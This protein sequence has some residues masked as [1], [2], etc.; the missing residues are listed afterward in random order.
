MRNT[1][2]ITTVEEYLAAVPE[3]AQSTLRKIRSTILAAAPAAVTESICYGM[4]MFKLNKVM[5][6]G[7]AAFKDHC[8]VFPGAQAVE[9]LAK[10]LKKYPTSKGTIRFPSDQPLP[11]TLIRKIVKLRIADIESRKRKAG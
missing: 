11:A 2:K 1:G 8:S 3:P 9:V 4:P 5:I 10:E 7:Y 6:A